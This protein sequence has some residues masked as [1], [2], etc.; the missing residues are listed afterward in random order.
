MVE[1]W[2]VKLLATFDGNK[3]DEARAF[4][5]HRLR[6][7]WF[8]TRTDYCNGMAMEKLLRIQ[9]VYGRARAPP[10]PFY[11]S[12]SAHAYTIPVIAFDM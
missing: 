5:P 2:G 7:L 12:A 6:R 3:S 9:G 4:V 10:L 8:E 1:A 11:L